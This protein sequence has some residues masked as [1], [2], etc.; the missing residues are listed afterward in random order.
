M[1]PT[2]C[3]Q[4][5]TPRP[6]QGTFWRV[7]MRGMP[8]RRLATRPRLS[9]LMGRGSVAVRGAPADRS[10]WSDVCP[11]HPG[12]PGSEAAGEG[13]AAGLTGALAP[14]STKASGCVLSPLLRLRPNLPASLGDGS[15][16]GSAPPAKGLKA[17]ACVGDSAERMSP[18]GEQSG[19]Q[20]AHGQTGQGAGCPAA[21]QRRPP[22]GAK[23]CAAYWSGR[24]A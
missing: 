14:S 15:D 1:E 8:A 3:A 2:C 6:P 16:P 24:A 11:T 12:A 9:A 5:A 22:A 19:K 20:P 18:R 17:A 4:S 7:R 10:S 13:G 23:C 21:G